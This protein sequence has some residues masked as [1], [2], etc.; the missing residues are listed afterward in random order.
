[1]ENTVWL[2]VRMKYKYTT[3]T[4]AIVFF[5]SHLDFPLPRLRRCPQ[6]AF[7][8]SSSFGRGIPIFCGQILWYQSGIN[9][10]ETA[11]LT[12]TTKPKKK[13]QPTKTSAPKCGFL[14]GTKFFFSYSIQKESTSHLIYL[15]FVENW[16]KKTIHFAFACQECGKQYFA[17]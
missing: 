16:E 1:M 15:F 11:T 4:D 10:K 2:I 3:K 6:F 13:K 14:S 12:T 8:T 7:I 9:V 17:I 5:I